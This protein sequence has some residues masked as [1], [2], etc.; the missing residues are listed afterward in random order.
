VYLSAHQDDVR[1]SHFS[2]ARTTLTSA[3]LALRGYHLH[4][5]LVGFYSSHNIRAIT[6]L[7]LRRCQLTGFYLRFILQ[8]HRLWC[9]RY[10]YGDVR[11][12]LIGYILCIIDYHIYWD[13]FDTIDIMYY[14]L[15]YVFRCLLLLKTLVLYIYRLR[16]IM[17]YNQQLYVIQYSVAHFSPTVLN[18]VVF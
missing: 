14:R 3:T 10:D 8:S 1:T 9:S 12:Y 2:T 16:G 15:P 7:Q 17:Q 5:V 18:K 13:I 6:T 4:V 11:V